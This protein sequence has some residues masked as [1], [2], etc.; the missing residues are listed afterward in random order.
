MITCLAY[1]IIQAVLIFI[2]L[3]NYHIIKGNWVFANDHAYMLCIANVVIWLS[4]IVLSCAGIFF[5]YKDL[6]ARQ[7]LPELALN[8][9]L[10]LINI[11]YSYVFDLHIDGEI[12]WYPI[13]DYL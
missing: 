13:F 4:T 5:A 8:L 9:P 7:N 10:V 12:D 1:C 3:Y 11:S 6:R 2:P